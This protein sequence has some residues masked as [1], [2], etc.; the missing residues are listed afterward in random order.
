LFRQ[1]FG[2]GDTAI[3]EG[4]SGPLA[5]P[6]NGSR[7]AAPFSMLI[8]ETVVGHDDPQP[9][10]AR[11]RREQC[12]TNGVDVQDI[13]TA[14]GSA[15]HPQESMDERFEARN[16]RRPNA[17]D[18]NVA[19]SCPSIFYHGAVANNRLDS[20]PEF[21]QRTRQFLDVF[22]H[23]TLHVRKAAHSEHGDAKDALPLLDDVGTFGR[24]T[25]PTLFPPGIEALAC[26][27]FHEL[28][29]LVLA[30]C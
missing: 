27:V 19:P 7:N 2:N 12:R 28:A 23:A 24:R 17:S 10:S 14:E 29:A 6:Q 3:R 21:G 16:M 20:A 18:R 30:R 13:G 1:T 9:K 8:V 25:C 22:F 4:H 11:E 5:E 26:R 15:D